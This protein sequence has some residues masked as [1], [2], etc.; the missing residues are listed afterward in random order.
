MRES[1]VPTKVCHILDNI[2]PGVG[3]T[4]VAYDLMTV[5][6]VESIGIYIGILNIDQRFSESGLTIRSSKNNLETIKELVRLRRAGFRT[7]H[8]HSRKAVPALIFANAIG[9]RVIRTQHFGTV[10]D[11]SDQTKSTRLF[12]RIKN[13]FTLQSF[14][15]TH[16]AAISDA[17]KAYIQDRWNIPDA[18]ISVI[19]NGVNTSAFTSSKDEVR[20]VLRADL[21]IPPK[22][23]VFVSVGSLYPRK[24]HNLT[25]T[26][27]Q[28]VVKREPDAMLIIAGEGS[29]RQKLQNQIAALSLS[30]NVRLLGVRSDVDRILSLV[31]SAIDEAFGLVVVE[32]NAA[33]LPAIVFDGYGPSEIVVDG[34]TGY[35]IPQKDT[36]A[37]AKAMLHLLNSPQEREAMGQR[38]SEAAKD[39]FSLQATR[40]AYAQ[41]YTPKPPQR[42]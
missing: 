1:N 31:H 29:D 19:Y 38:A 14:W 36:D 6:S 35:I 18:R 22:S 8:V 9:Y 41:L 11:V 2:R 21:G 15:I 30:E 20:T 39:R 5:P 17:S 23:I 24:Y 7:I 40:K 28:Q 32:G 16:W 13:L 34:V 37:M 27:F 26:A 4:Q 42:A 10:G 12:R 33:A 25:I 3:V